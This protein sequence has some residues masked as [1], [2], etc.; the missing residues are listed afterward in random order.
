[1]NNKKAGERFEAW[2][3]Y[4]L[5]EVEKRN[6]INYADLHNPSYYGWPPTDKGVD[7]VHID[8]INKVVRVVQV[9]HKKTG[10]VTYGSDKLSH[11][12]AMGGRFNDSQAAKDGYSIR[13]V[14]ITN[15]AKCTGI[16]EN[17]TIY[18]GI[19]EPPELVLVTPTNC[20][21]ASITATAK[22]TRA[23]KT[24]NTKSA[25]NGGD[26]DY[27]DANLVWGTWRPGYK[28]DKNNLTTENSADWLYCMRKF[29]SEDYLQYKYSDMHDSI[30]SHARSGKD[31]H[32]QKKGW[33]IYKN[34]HTLDD[35]IENIR[36]LDIEQEVCKVK[37]F[38][39]LITS[40]IYEC[41]VIWQLDCLP[42]ELHVIITSVFNKCPLMQYIK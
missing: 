29:L 41:Y 7:L 25:N 5:Y 39:D 36:A 6:Y 1:M 32:L 35:R 37:N 18:S 33:E 34:I 10:N 27:T 17:I 38:K 13:L 20:S 22:K 31:N 19:Q 40:P 12:E 15:A 24:A 26:V 28:L 30:K 21:P 9:K 14:V 4:Y 42:T 8:Q 3:R 2:S 23:K 16:S 11:L